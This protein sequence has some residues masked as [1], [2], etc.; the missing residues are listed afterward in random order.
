MTDYSDIVGAAEIILGSDSR[1]TDIAYLQI[2]KGNN[3]T[4]ETGGPVIVLPGFRE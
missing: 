1:S 4:I 2:S 3:V